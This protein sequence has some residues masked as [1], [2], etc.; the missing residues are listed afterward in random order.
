[1]VVPMASD[2]SW[3]Y[4]S[5]ADSSNVF[6]QGTFWGGGDTHHG[7][8][9]LDTDGNTVAFSINGLGDATV[10]GNIS[11]GNVTG[12]GSN[13]DIVAGSYDW[14]FGNDGNLTLPGNT[15]AV[16]Y[17]N[18]TPVSLGGNYSDSNTGT[19]VY[20]SEN[21]YPTNF[22]TDEGTVTWSG[23]EIINSANAQNGSLQLAQVTKATS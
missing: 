12:S 18:G 21:F 10:S 1:M 3:A 20:S 14:I 16:N 7:F 19:N 13:V 2:T 4:G 22:F 11:V 6:L 17:A 15:F 23:A 8:R 5:F 9:I